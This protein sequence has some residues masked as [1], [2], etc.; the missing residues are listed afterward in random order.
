MRAAFADDGGH[1][2]GIGLPL[3]TPVVKRILI[4]IFAIWGVEFLISLVA[5]GLL[6]TRVV[7]AT[8][9][10][11]TGLLPTF[12]LTPAVWF[13]VFPWVYPWQFV[14][15]GFLHSP[16]YVWHILSNAIGLFFFGTM[17]EGILG[18]RRFL[19]FYLSAVVVA[20][21]ISLLFKLALGSTSYTVGASGG[22]FAAIFAAATMRPRATVYFFF[23]PLPLLWLALGF[24][25]LNLV[26]FLQEIF[27]GA[28]SGT[29]HAA[30]L[31]G[32]GFGFLAVRRGF[33]WRDLFEALQ[34]KRAQREQQSQVADEQRLDEL[35]QRIHEKGIQS[36]SEREKAFLK[37]MSKRG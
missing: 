3:L 23:F 16:G 17:L 33:I 31:A 11:E 9:T 6:Q 5:P 13:E 24:L 25:L 26:P 14:T 34:E 29:D 32:A 20:G 28:V 36:L 35:L 1:G 18:S 8:G 30:H 37:R 21:L 2:G 19:G 7:T 22:V 15:Y 10:Y 12:G 4:L 27:T